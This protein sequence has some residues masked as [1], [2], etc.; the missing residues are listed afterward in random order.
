MLNKG[1]LIPDIQVTGTDGQ[2]IRLWD[3]RQKGH[4]LLVL[5]RDAARR[6]KWAADV[7]AHQKLWD[8]LSIR[9]MMIQAAPEGWT[10]AAYG[11]DRFGHFLE[12]FS[13][14]DSLWECVEREFLY[15]EARH[16]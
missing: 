11:I 1:K 9:P 5:V 6:E 16:C 7:K 2:S 8:W 4:L 3:Y 13:L 12:K 14:D 15:H 10:E